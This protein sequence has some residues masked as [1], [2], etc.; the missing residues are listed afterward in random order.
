MII[1]NEIPGFSIDLFCM[2]HR[3]EFKRVYDQY[4]TPLYIFA[5]NL[6]RNGEA[7]DMAA[8]AFIKL[9]NDR[10]KFKTLQNIKAYLYVVTRNAC[11]DYLRFL[12]RQREI[13]KDVLYLQE[14]KENQY[15]E[16]ISP[17]ALNKIYQLIKALPDKCRKIFELIYFENLTT[18]Q[19]ATRLR[20]SNQNV[21][22]Q[23]A[24]AIQILRASLWEAGL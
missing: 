2:G 3:D 4:Y 11:I 13:V 5:H 14:L 6:L 20:I 24:R 19:V 17:E 8:I 16:H 9:W 21:L 10:H 1:N 18:T 23:K 12:Q 7:A 22:N 15:N